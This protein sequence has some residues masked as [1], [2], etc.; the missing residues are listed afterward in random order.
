MSLQLCRMHLDAAVRCFRLGI[1]GE[2][3]HHLIAYIDTA[4][5]LLEKV[6]KH[7]LQRI[8]PLLNRIVSA[9]SH[10]DFLCVA[11]LLEYENL[12]PVLPA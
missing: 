1:E 9:Q 4:M 7:E 5:P 11:D 12:L 10:R 6:P 2:G 3:S 8:T